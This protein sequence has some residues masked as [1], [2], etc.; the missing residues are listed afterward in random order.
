[1]VGF[2]YA[3]EG[4]PAYERSPMAKM[5]EM[6]RDGYIEFRPVDRVNLSGMT[7]LEAVATCC[8]IRVGIENLLSR[9]E[10]ACILAR[11]QPLNLG[12]VRPAIRLLAGNAHDALFRKRR[13]QRSGSYLRDVTF[14]AIRPWAS[15]KMDFVKAIKEKHDIKRDLLVHRDISDVRNWG[16]GIEADAIRKIAERFSDGEVLPF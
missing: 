12:S 8:M 11:Y 7:A 13:M 16:H 3:M 4:M 10:Q 9:H 1:M 2:C 15:H 6:Y 5:E 14:V